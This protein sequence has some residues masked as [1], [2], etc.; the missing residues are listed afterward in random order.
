MGFRRATGRTK[1]LE[2]PKAAAVVTLAA[3]D[4][5][6][7]SADGQVNRWASDTAAVV[8]GVC[9]ETLTDTG[10]GAVKIEVPTE[11]YV[12]FEFDTDTDGGLADSDVGR[13]VDVD[14]NSNVDVSAST[15]DTVY[16]TKR[17]SATK[18]RGVLARTP[19]TK[20][21]GQIA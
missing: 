13:F 15:E 8:V 17:I 10:T 3:G 18:G 12:E 1:L 21:A 2:F 9:R 7:L 19:I 6:Q 14:S 16:V 20:A 4:L 5:I 11:L